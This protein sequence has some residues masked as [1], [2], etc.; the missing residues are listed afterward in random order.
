MIELTW[1]GTQP[2]KLPGGVERRFI[3]D[4]DTIILRGFAEKDGVRIGF[5]EASVTILPA[6]EQKLKVNDYGT[7]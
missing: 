7:Q 6:K 3:E 1:N 4:H 5:G 2:L